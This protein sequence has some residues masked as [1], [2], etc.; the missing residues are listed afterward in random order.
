MVVDE[1]LAST[2]PDL[3]AEQRALLLSR[4][5]AHESRVDA[6]TQNVAAARKGSAGGGSRAR[7]LRASPALLKEQLDAVKASR[8][9]GCIRGCGWSRSSASGAI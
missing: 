5:E 1:E 2:R 6:L 7:P 4:R 8:T 9:R 3:V